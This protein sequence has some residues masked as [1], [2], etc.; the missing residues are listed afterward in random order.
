[1]FI[2]AL[3]GKQISPSEREL[4]ELP[5]RLGGMNL[6]NPVKTADKHYQDSKHITT[7]LCELIKQQNLNLEEGVLSIARSDVRKRALEQAQENDKTI[8][9]K[10]KAI[11]EKLPVLC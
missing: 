2:P 1:M 9:E 8:T 10:H 4:I 5:C 7:P 6:K 11:L 3:L